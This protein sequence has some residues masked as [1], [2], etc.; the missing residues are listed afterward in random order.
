MTSQQEQQ[1][2][3]RGEKTAENVRY[4]QAIS[5]GGM[6]G[7]T[8]EAGGNANQGKDDLRVMFFD[9]V[10]ENADTCMQA[11]LEKQTHREEQ[12]I[13]LKSLG[14]TRAMGQDLALGH[15]LFR[16][17]EEEFEVVNSI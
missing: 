17:L 1:K 4:G 8:T 3:E 6:G 2:T 16:D 7:K 12:R 15:R 11:D 13:V 9:N 5:E 10:A 14:G